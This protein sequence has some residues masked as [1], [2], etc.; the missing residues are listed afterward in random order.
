MFDYAFEQ[1]KPA[2]APR[3]CVLTTARGDQDRTSA[4]FRAAF[5]GREVELS[6]VSLFD[7]P[8]V[9]DVVQHLRSQDA[10]WVDRG[11]VV[12]ALAV[13]RAH[14]VDAVLRD[15]WQE[16]VVLAGES[17]GSLCWFSGGT[18]GSF[19]RVRAVQDGL[20]VSAVF[21]RRALL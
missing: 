5:E 8:N 12:N 18:T 14:R 16:G 6:C 1:A 4:Q 9:D 2:G 11:S 15:C 10:I 13:W 7:Q 3:L 19:G 21:E 17:A 20:G